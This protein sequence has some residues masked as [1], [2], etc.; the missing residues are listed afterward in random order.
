M[1]FERMVVL[2]PRK[3]RG[4][5]AVGDPGVWGTRLASCQNGGHDRRFLFKMPPLVPSLKKLLPASS[6]ATS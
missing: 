1:S 2:E 6:I 3:V 4:R 5:D